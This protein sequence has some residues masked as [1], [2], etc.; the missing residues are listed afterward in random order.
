MSA[1]TTTA[2]LGL[3][4]APVVYA[5]IAFLVRPGGPTLSWP[6]PGDPM[7]LALTLAALVAAVAGLVLPA[8]MAARLKSG[9]AGAGPAGDARRAGAER[10]VMLVRGA[11]FEM[12][13]V[14]GFVIVFL[15]APAGTVLPFAA[16]SFAL[17]LSH[18][19]TR[20]RLSRPFD[21]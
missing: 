8:R 14:A 20:E 11:L 9:L 7:Q 1:E 5:A 12:S 13:A 17:L 10:M 6:D 19:P 21:S 16:L 2:W 3:T 4:A 15:G 18:F